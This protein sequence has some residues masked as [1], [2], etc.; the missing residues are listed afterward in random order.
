MSLLPKKNYKYNRE[1]PLSEGPING[2]GLGAVSGMKFGL[3]KMSRSGCEV[4]AV[5]NALLLHHKPADFL[6]IARY[7]ER[8]RMLMGFWGT[9]YLAL[10][11]C[12]R[13][14]GLPAK[15][16][17][18]PKDVAE[19]LHAGRDVMFVYWCGKRLRSSVHT[20]ILRAEGETLC[21]YNAYN[22]YGKIYRASFEEY[23]E[24]RHMITAYVILDDE[25]DKK[26]G[27]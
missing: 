4:I 6:K 8:F 14:Y 10:G 15:R 20:I 9:N 21:V 1:I 26:D 13:R 25:K 2:Q 19:A 5:Y 23:L 27:I 24:K 17:H 18:H 22:R 12:L 11:H 7:M 3:S 16:V